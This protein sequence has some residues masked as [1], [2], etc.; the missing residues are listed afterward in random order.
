MQSRIVSC[1]C[2]CP[3]TRSNRYGSSRG[4][5]L[6]AVVRHMGLD[7]VTSSQSAEKGELPSEHGRCDDTGEGLSILA[8]LLRVGTPDPEH[9]EDT[10]L[11]CEARSAANGADFDA[12]HR[13]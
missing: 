7:E 10:L 5:D 3:G 1:M 13:H 6:R 2:L 8:R 12:G 4:I 11:G 9:L